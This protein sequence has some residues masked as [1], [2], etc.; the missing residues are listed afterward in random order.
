MHI[1]I[2]QRNNAKALGLKRYFSGKPCP[3]GHI[4][5]RNICGGCIA[6]ARTPEYYARQ[7]VNIE[8]FHKRNPGK[9]KEYQDKYYS[10]AE[11]RVV[12]SKK[13][14]LYR[15]N[16]RESVL[17]NQRR[18]RKER[19]KS[20]PEF[21]MAV[22]CR[23][24]VRRVTRSKKSSAFEEIGYI[25]DKLMKRMECQFKPGMS[26]DNYG[27]WEI[28]HKKPVARFI[29]QGCMN[30]AVINALSNL[31]PLWKS[32]NRAKGDKYGV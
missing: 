6:C 17:E 24:M 18:Y 4:S 14:K 5:E 29:A 1:H 15:E 19:Y 10:K 27:D 21:K 13:R 9:K 28:D 26:W 3:H 23:L 11:S 12:D 7:K 20:S 25:P 16:N 30:P 32:E 8:N 2:I 22:K 31:Q